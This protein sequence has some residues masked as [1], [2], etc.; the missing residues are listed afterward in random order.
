LLAMGRALEAV[1][2]LERAVRRAEDAGIETL[3]ASALTASGRL[4]DALERLQQAITRRPAYPPAFIEY[5]RQLGRAM[6]VDDAIAV[7]AAGLALA[8][9]VIE[10]QVELARLLVVS[11][12]RGRARTLLLQAQA[13]APGHPDVLGE[14]ARI[15]LLD[16][17][18]A[19]AADFYR[20]AL[21]ARPDAMTRANFALCLLEL[22][23]RNAAETQLREVVRDSPQLFG[24]AVSSMAVSSHGR[25]FMRPSLAAKFLKA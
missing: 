21:A 11:N 22:N 1:P 13:A 17:E 14:L 9:H 3:L 6:K 7:A 5:A 23:D 16:G 10:L 18:Y 24:R 15:M 12:E 4:P 25:F 20:R 2:P 8:P 19:A